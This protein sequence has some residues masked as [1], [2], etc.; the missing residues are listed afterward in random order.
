ML[1]ARRN[2]GRKKSKRIKEFVTL[3]V[4]LFLGSGVCGAVGFGHCSR[5]VAL[6]IISLAKT[7]KIP[8]KDMTFD[9][10]ASVVSKRL[11]NGTVKR[12]GGEWRQR[13]FGQ[14]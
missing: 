14:L 5:F 3:V 13:R 9:Q 6:K 4:N 2:D 1:L 10:S 7:E 12:Q 8:L 11:V